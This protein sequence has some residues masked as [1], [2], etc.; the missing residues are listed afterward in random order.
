MAA[1]GL[2]L[3]G[4]VNAPEGVARAE[5][6][7]RI[8]KGASFFEDFS[9][10]DRKRWFVS[11]GWTNGPYQGCGWSATNARLTSRGITLILNHRRTAERPLSCG[12][13]QT[14]EFYAHGTYEVRMRSVAVPGVVSAFFTYTGPP[15]AAG[16][17][18]DEISFEFLGNKPGGVQ[19]N[20]FAQGKGDHGRDVELGFDP[21]A[22]MND[23]AFQWTS[24]AMRW[25]VNRRLVH[26]VKRDPAAP[27]P[28]QPGKIILSIW[29]GIGPDQEAWMG[30]LQ[31]AG[32]PLAATF[33]YVAFTAL[34][35][36]C[37]FPASVLCGD[38]REPGR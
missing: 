26:E 31:Y 29:T 5:E 17:P 14:R 32:S 13:L 11:D 38:G 23:Y 4:L 19:L 34:G 1:V 7:T 28:A 37:R 10:L 3:G 25:F 8:D 24:D 18:H 36:P 21:S 12:E 6:A 2:L 27:F 9:K 16:R 15:H 20:Y 22:A 35:E 30:R 33:E